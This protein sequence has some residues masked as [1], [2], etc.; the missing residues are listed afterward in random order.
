M[1][2]SPSP[3]YFHPPTY[4]FPPMQT[5]SLFKVFILSPLTVCLV[6]N[7]YASGNVCAGTLCGDCSCE[8][9][10]FDPPAPQAGVPPEKLDESPYDTY[11]YSTCLKVTLSP[12]EIDDIIADMNL[13]SELVLT[14]SDGTLD[15]QMDYTILPHTYTGFTAP[16]FVIGPFEIDDELLNPLS[17]TKTDF[18]YVVSGFRD[19]S[20]DLELAAWCGSS[21]GELSVHGAGYSYIQY[22]RGACNSVTV[23]GQ[24]IYEPLIHE[25]MHNLDWALYYINQVPDIYQDGWPDWEHWQPASWPACGTGST[26]S[27]D[28]FPSVDLCEWDPDWLDCTNTVSAGVCLHAGDV[29]GQI[30]W[31]EHVIAAHYPRDLL[32]VG[33]FCRDTARDYPGIS[34]DSYWQCP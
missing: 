22:N 32:F 27:Q 31:Y 8:W 13:V 28:W 10:D 7:E 16:D 29:G 25:W 24:L 17:S 21:Y 2:G 18:V 26:N 3:T 1:I 23:D 14:W 15:L 5:R 11:R 19:P 30:S 34:A 6:G 20:L 4:T 33:N 12:E 9:N